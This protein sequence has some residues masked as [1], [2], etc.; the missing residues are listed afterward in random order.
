M[1][2]RVVIDGVVR[3]VSR[4]AQLT[5]RGM[6]HDRLAGDGVKGSGPRELTTLSNYK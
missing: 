5:K 1:R 3:G 6:A 4:R 2:A